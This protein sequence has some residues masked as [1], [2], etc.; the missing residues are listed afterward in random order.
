MRRRRTTSSATRGVRRPPS[1][2][3]LRALLAVSPL[4]VLAA[5]GGGGG[6]T[7]VPSANAAVAATPAA[8]LR[9][10]TVL[11][12]AQTLAVGGFDTARVERLAWRDGWTGAARLIMDPTATEALGSI[13][14]GRVASVTVQP[15]DRV[16]RGQLMVALHSHEMMDAR[17]SL[18]AAE[19]GATRARTALTLAVTAAERAERLHAAR[20]LSQAE[21]ERARASRDDA[22]ANVSQADAEL[23]RATHFLEHLLGDG[24]VP[25][26]TD[27]HHVLVR[28]P[29]DGVVVAR[30]AEPGAVVT[31]GAP[32]V[33]VSRT[34]GLVLVA[35]LPETHGGDVGVGSSIEFTVAAVP[36]RR[37]SARV[38]RVSPVVDSVTRSVEVRANV[39]DGG[40]LRPEMFATAELLG[41]AGTPVLTVASEAVQAMA[42][43]TVVVTYDQRGEGALLEAVP[44]R[45]GRRAGGRAEIISG[46]PDST[47]VVTTG[48]AIA[49]AELLRRRNGAE[50]P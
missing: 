48:A 5:C 22:Q 10:D 24:P 12:S 13:V 41:P 2:L 43:D 18:A 26:G 49:K 16:R 23:S 8:T 17:A 19:A 34:T 47:R 42:G 21:L 7:A 29:F 28:A 1:A 38:S 6:E 36:G 3:P 15:G 31:V 32:L 40:V 39:A 46:L 45:V 27:P 14:E 33:T 44:V 25:A 37:F 4:V 9:R 20:A 30:Q 50:A 35:R 11:L